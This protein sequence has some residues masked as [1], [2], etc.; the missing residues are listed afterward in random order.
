MGLCVYGCPLRAGLGAGWAGWSLLTP[1]HC[2]RLCED[3][4]PCHAGRLTPVQ[5]QLGN[6]WLAKQGRHDV[7]YVPASFLLPRRRVHDD[8]LLIGAG[9]RHNP[10]SFPEVPSCRAVV[11]REGS[12]GS[13][14]GGDGVLGQDPGSSLLS[15]SLNR[16][17]LL[18]APG[19]CHRR[20]P[21]TGR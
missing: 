1:N 10:T 3:T 21:G 5:L 15:L 17:P 13:S 12:G 7:P 18:S 19:C 6:C 11:T 2:E 4:C 14:P 20:V 8:G 9:H 16:H